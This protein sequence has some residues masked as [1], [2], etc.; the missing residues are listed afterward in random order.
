MC[1]VVGDPIITG[2]RARIPLTVLTPTHPCICPEKEPQCLTS[3]LIE[4]VFMFNEL[5]LEVIVRLLILVLLLSITVF[6]KVEYSESKIES[7]MFL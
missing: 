7:L 6:T 3:D 1:V 2:R 4:S 5:S